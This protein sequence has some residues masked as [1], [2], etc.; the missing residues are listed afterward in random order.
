MDSEEDYIIKELENEIKSVSFSCSSKE[1][2]EF[3]YKRAEKN[4]ED[5]ISKIYIYYDINNKKIFGFISL[6]AYQLN[7]SD[8]EKFGISS[9][10]AVLLGRLA[11]DNDYRKKNLGENLIKYTCIIGKE[12][13]KL[14]GCR[15][16]IV[17][18]N[19][20]DINLL[21]YFIDKGFTIVRQSKRF[22]YL[23]IDL[24]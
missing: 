10:P 19:S 16:L 3:L 8:T 14:V 9:V 6:S 5:L 23:M 24:K 7:L 13:K 20:G 2:N 1:L 15:L 11:I 12:V 21:N 17:E 22:Y 18:V 4:N